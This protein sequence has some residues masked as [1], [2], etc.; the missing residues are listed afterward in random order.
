MATLRKLVLAQLVAYVNKLCEYREHNTKSAVHYNVHYNILIMYI[1]SLLLD[2]ISVLYGEEIFK[3]T[4]PDKDGNVVVEMSRRQFNSYINRV[5]KLDRNGTIAINKL[6]DVR[7]GIAHNFA[8]ASRNYSSLLKKVD[9]ELCFYIFKA[10]LNKLDVTDEF[11]LNVYKLLYDMFSDELGNMPGYAGK[12]FSIELDMLE[13][14]IIDKSCKVDVV[15][16]KATEELL[17]Q[18]AEK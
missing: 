12:L 6:F 18:L 4:V 15:S 7:N 14:A 3:D 8:Y 10:V 13:D 11:R 1:I 5:Y 17:K 9:T 2:M 16:D